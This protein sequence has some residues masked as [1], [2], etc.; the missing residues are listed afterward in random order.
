M[1]ILT[2]GFPAGHGPW[3]QTILALPIDTPT[4]QRR[5]EPFD[6]RVSRI[7]ENDVDSKIGQSVSSTMMY[8]PKLAPIIY[9]QTSESKYIF[10]K[11]S[12]KIK[13]IVFT[14]FNDARASQ[15]AIAISDTFSRPPAIVQSVRVLC[16]RLSGT[17][18]GR[19]NVSVWR[20]L[21]ALI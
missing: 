9:V 19:T 17:T 5:A 14:N 4:S 13:M 3:A 20:N 12:R 11:V 15:L 10:V 18:F 6:L 2:S 16:L 1:K 7:F 21:V 8:S